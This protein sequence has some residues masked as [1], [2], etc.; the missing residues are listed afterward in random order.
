MKKRSDFQYKKPSNV[1]IKKT[2]GDFMKNI[3]LLSILSLSLSNSIQ[4][5]SL[6]GT[7]ENYIN[8][9]TGKII[10]VASNQIEDD[11][12]TSSYLDYESNKKISIDLR[13]YSKATRQEIAGVKAGEMVL[14]KINKEF[15]P[16][17][18]WH[19]FENKMGFISCKTNQIRKNIGVD[20]PV[21]QQYLVSNIESDIIIS[22]VAEK[23][24][25]KKHD[26]AET[27]DGMKIRIES[28]FNNGTVLVQ[29]MNLSFLDTSSVLMK[30][31]IIQTNLTNLKK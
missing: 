20:R 17:E 16:C 9:H 6:I 30:Y 26:F 7:I 4:A 24:G 31:N 18:V 22:E 19:L 12:V 10:E 15:E 13:D 5:K 3:F 29:K 1:I 27:M 21:L 25:F 8:I 11:Q 23:D 14:A 28:I 2:T